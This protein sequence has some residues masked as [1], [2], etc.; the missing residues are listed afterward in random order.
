MQA[1]LSHT[2]FDLT[3]GL[4]P[5]SDA[6]APSHWVSQDPNSTVG[7]QIAP[8]NG[9]YTYT[10]TFN[11][12]GGRYGGNL[13]FLADDTLEFILNGVVVPFKNNSIN[14]ACAQGPGPGA[15]C[16]GN[17][18]K[19]V[20]GNPVVLNPGENTLTVIDWQSNGSAAGVDFE[21]TL[22]KT[23]EPGSL[24]LLGTGLVGLVKLIARKAH[25]A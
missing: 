23:P 2:T 22:T 19:Y 18:F 24:L 7:L 25:R 9:Y 15:T 8:T 6:I 1:A 21:G 16:V 3:L 5:W 14:G 12:D 20:F 17:P 10:S 4:P 13:S 11:A